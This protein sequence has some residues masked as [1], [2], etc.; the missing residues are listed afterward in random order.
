MGGGTAAALDLYTRLVASPNFRTWL[1]V[2]RGALASLVPPS[3]PSPR[4]GPPIAPGAV[5]GAEWFD[6]ARQHM[7]EVELINVFWTQEQK[8][9]EAMRDGAEQEVARCARDQL[10]GPCRSLAI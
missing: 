3:P 5:G 6:R 8:L 2:H 1:A 9:R 7:D 10:K 4:P